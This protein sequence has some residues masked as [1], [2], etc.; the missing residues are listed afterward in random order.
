MGCQALA[1][2]LPVFPCWLELHAWGIVHLFAACLWIVFVV[3]LA[4]ASAH[5][6][7]EKEGN[8]KALLSLFRGKNTLGYSSIS[9]IYFLNLQ[10]RSIKRYNCVLA[11]CSLKLILSLI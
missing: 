9:F 4:L 10:I 11:V 6:K 8:K 2:D 5:H 1:L 3:V 7:Q